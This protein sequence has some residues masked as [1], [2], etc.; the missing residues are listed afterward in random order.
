M[1]QLENNML[2]EAFNNFSTKV[3]NEHVYNTRMVSRGLHVIPMVKTKAYGLQ[4]VKNICINDWNNF[5]MLFPD[6]INEHLTTY[7]IKHLFK[8]KIFSHYI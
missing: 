4:S 5:K 2:P 8:N 7:K 1:H 6:H 3:R